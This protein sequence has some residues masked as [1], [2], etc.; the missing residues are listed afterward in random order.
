MW[1]PMLAGDD[2]E[3]IPNDLLTDSRATRFWDPDRSVGK[4]FA[5]HGLG[6]QPILW[7]AYVLFDAQARWNDH[8]TPLAWGDPII[9]NTD[10]LRS[11]LATHL[12]S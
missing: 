1:M 9:G 3:A 4:W 7:D 5:D 12:G 6:H 11:A 8:A 10:T 2:R